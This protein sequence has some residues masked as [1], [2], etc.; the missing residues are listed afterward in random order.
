MILYT[1]NNI[2]YIQKKNAKDEINKNFKREHYVLS[3]LLLNFAKTARF[4]DGCKRVLGFVMRA[5]LFMQKWRGSL[6]YCIL[7]LIFIN[8]RKN[9]PINSLTMLVSIYSIQ[10]PTT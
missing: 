7:I 9:N 10:Q 3:F 4:T 2:Y 6:F 1:V 8:E 5:L